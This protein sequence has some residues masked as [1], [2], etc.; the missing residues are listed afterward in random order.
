MYLAQ[1]H[2]IYGSSRVGVDNR[3]DTLYM[4]AVYTPTWG[5]VGT[6][7]RDLGSKSFEL[8]NH[9]GNVL[10]TVSDKPVYNVS[11]GTIFFNPEITS[12]SDYYP[13]G[14][15]IQGRGY[16]NDVYRF[17]YNGGEA[18]NE[19]YGKDNYVDLVERGVDTRLGRLNWSIDP[20]SKEYPW[21]SPYAYYANSPIWQIDY[22]GMGKESTHTDKDGNVV[23]VYNDEDNGVYKHDDLSKWNPNNSSLSKFGQGVTKMGETEHWDEFV[24]PETGKTL[25]NYKMQF[26]KSFDPLVAQMHEKAKN[27]D[28]KEIASKSAGGQLFDIKKDYVGV[29]ALLNGKY[30][31]SRSAGNF[32]AGYN[33]KHATYLGVGISFTTFQQLAGALHIEESNGKLLSKGQMI[34][35][36]IL[37]TYQSSDINKF[38]APTYGEVNYQ[39]RMS[40]AGWNFVKKK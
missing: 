7:R 22:L 39:Y 6:S 20:L 1:E 12:I 28:L 11:S 31:T 32:L 29:G 23:A 8:A 30:A 36:V 18:I 24:S 37:G 35:I 15:P 26:G 19:V 5:G 2:S 3:K 33:A 4:G 40:L 21:Q 38:V 34:D 13:F 16:S 9:L 10:V 14:A 27:M 17:S 25:T